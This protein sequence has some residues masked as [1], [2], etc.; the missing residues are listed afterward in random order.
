MLFYIVQID[1]PNHNLGVHLEI[2]MA[3]II[4]AKVYRCVLQPYLPI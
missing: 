2:R 1:T 4:S 3:S